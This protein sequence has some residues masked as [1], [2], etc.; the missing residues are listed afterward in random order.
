MS[1]NTKSMS[2]NRKQCQHQ[3]IQ[4]QCQLNKQYQLKETMLTN[5]KQC[6]L[7]ETM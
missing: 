4:K 6:Q 7:I 1:T 3:L 5:N 2:T